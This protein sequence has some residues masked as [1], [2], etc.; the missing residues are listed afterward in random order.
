MVCEDMTAEGYSKEVLR[1]LTVN[2][3]RYCLIAIAI[4]AVV[5]T[6]LLLNA[7]GPEGPP[8]PSYVVWLLLLP[9]VYLMATIWAAVG[10]A[11]YKGPDGGLPR[12]DG[13]L[14]VSII[15]LFVPKELLK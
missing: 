5:L 7:H 12:S 3:W 14:V 15:I 2:R 1:D 9:L 4:V 11:I 10:Y 6:L 8:S 13:N